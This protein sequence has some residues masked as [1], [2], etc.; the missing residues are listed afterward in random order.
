MKHFKFLMIAL[1]FVLAACGDSSGS[2]AKKNDDKADAGKWEEIKEAGELVVGTSG[3]LF[4][5]SYYPEGSDKLTGYDAEVIR[6]IAKRLDL[7]VTFETI[8]IDGLLAAV[9]SNRIDVAINDIEI[10]DERK[11]QFAFTDPYK[12]SFTSL[13]VRSDDLSGIE[14]LEDLKGKKAGGGATTV[15][16]DIAR[17]FGAEVVTYSNVSNDVYLQDVNNGRTDTVINDYYLQK[18]ALKAITRFDIKIHPDIKFHPTEQGIVVHKDATKLVQKMNQ[19]L[20]EMRDDGTL[21]ELA[22]KFYG[23]EDVSKQP[24]AEIRE[25]KELDL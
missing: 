3:T 16:S 23:G 17:H 14:T 9:N 4:A 8:G 15:F 2:E 12:Y 6:E 1:L 20:Q 7:N 21:T 5:A 22:K 10:T 19:A 18:L 11:K 24:E 25:I 13:I